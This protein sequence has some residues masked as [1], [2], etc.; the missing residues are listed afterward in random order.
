VTP[1][2]SLPQER[3]SQPEITTKAGPGKTTGITT[4]ADGKSSFSTKEGQVKQPQ[5]SRAPGPGRTTGI[6]KTADGKSSFK[7]V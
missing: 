6:T 7:R 4:A 5:I 2:D 1:P 3:V